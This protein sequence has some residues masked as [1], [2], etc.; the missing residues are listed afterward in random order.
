MLVLSRKVGERILI[1]N[2]VTL[3]VLSVEGQ[4]IRLGIEAPKTVAIRRE[5]LPP[6]QSPAPSA[7]TKSS[8]RPTGD[9][10]KM[11]VTACPDDGAGA[12]GSR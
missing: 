3:V 2:E 5:E 1:G 10:G 4:R 7:A 6:H 11:I 8:G 9:A 12:L